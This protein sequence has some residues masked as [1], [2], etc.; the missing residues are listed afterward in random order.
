MTTV[1]TMVMRTGRRTLRR[2]GVLVE[3]QRCCMGG[4]T[5]VGVEEEDNDTP[6]DE[7][8]AGHCLPSELLVAGR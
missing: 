4:T 6:A 8:V 1:E 2:V 5:E 7:P 3:R